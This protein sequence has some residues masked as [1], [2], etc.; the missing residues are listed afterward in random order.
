MKAMLPSAQWRGAWRGTQQGEE[1][2]CRAIQ[3]EGLGGERK[4][5]GIGEYLGEL[6]R[7]LAGTR[8]EGEKQA[9]AAGGELKQRGTH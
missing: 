7:G 4:R 1:A 8:G 9:G 6:C 2:Q 5:V 3:L